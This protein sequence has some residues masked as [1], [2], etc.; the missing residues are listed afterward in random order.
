MESALRFRT[1]KT[2]PS[3]V[4][5]GGGWL[6]IIPA[7]SPYVDTGFL[8]C[9]RKFLFY[10]KTK[11]DFVSILVTEGEYFRNISFLRKVSKKSKQNL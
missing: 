9:I 10:L 2:T 5:G 4:G 7:L 1:L 11:G 6:G 8:V 3:G